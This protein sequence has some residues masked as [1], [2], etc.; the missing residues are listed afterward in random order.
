MVN[1]KNQTNVREFRVSAFT[2]GLAVTGGSADK[3]GVG[4]AFTGWGLRTVRSFPQAF[5]RDCAG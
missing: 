2:E 5:P 3:E 1:D 4:F